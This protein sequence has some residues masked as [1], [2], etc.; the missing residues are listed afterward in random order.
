MMNTRPVL[1]VAAAALSVFALSACGGG[2]DGPAPAPAPVATQE[3][4]V[5]DGGGGVVDSQE[6]EGDAS[7]GSALGDAN[8]GGYLFVLAPRS[9]FAQGGRVVPSATVLRLR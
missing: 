1:T 2:G 3:G 4:G 9:V 5:S 8:R 7:T 6:G